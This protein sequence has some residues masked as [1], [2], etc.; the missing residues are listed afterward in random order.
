[1]N[2]NLTLGNNVKYIGDSAFRMVELTNLLD[3]SD[4]KNLIS[5]GESNPIFK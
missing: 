1:M 3:K 5:V 2:L 4:Y